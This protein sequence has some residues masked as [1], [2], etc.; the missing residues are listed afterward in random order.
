VEYDLVMQAMRLAVWRMDVPSRT[1]EIEIDYRDHSN[2]ISIPPGT[3]T[4]DV[5][6]QILPEYQ[7]TVKKGLEDLLTGRVEVFHL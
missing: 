6:A 2:S 1:M 7:E 5:V 4:T 3:K